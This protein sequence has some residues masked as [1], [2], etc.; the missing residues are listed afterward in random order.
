MAWLSANA[1]TIVVLVILAVLV[2]AVLFKLIRDHKRGITLC[3]ACAS[4]DSCAIRAAGKSCGDPK[5]KVADMEPQ[6]KKVK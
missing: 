4:A 6:I 5:Q 1:G 2:G 3:D